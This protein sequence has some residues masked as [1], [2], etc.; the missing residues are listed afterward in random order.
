MTISPDLLALL[1]CPDTHQPLTQCPDATLTE[2][3]GRIVSGTVTN[4]SGS[5]VEK[6]L[7]GA[8]IREDGTVAYPIAEGIPVLLAGEGIPL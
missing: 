4:A 8:L 5:S 7:T 2:L 3:N 1:V 6:P